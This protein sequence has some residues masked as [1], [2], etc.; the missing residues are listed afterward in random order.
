MITVDQFLSAEV[1][2]I[3]RVYS[4]KD[5][6]C[7]CGCGGDYVDTSHMEVPRSVVNDS[8]AAKRLRR[9]QR[10]YKSGAETDFGVTY[11]NV[12]TGNNRALTV[13]FDEVKK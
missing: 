3:S 9:A 13:Y 12:V 1:S 11:V 2:N 5:R 4:G 6:H 10:L 7:R 8:K